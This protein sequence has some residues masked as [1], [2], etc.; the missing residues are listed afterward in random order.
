[1]VAGCMRAIGVV[2]LDEAIGER[3]SASIQRPRC[4][5]AVGTVR[6]AERA[7][8]G[9]RSPEREDENMSSIVETC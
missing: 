3:Y 5:A 9:P 8:L 6:L 4:S 7:L 1:M 2:R